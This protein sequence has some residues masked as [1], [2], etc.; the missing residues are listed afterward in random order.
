MLPS[1]CA[2]MIQ[3]QEAIA[4]YRSVSAGRA[5]GVYQQAR[6][7]HELIILSKGGSLLRKVKPERAH[8]RLS[9]GV[10]MAEQG[11]DVGQQHIALSDSVPD[12]PCSLLHDHVSFWHAFLAALPPSLRGHPQED[13]YHV[14]TPTCACSFRVP[15]SIHGGR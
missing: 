6:A 7:K 14:G 10:G 3:R 12:P 1:C 13:V 5:E 2:H 15:N 11:V 4:S 9:S 8:D